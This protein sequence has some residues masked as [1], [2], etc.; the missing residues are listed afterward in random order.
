MYR[1]TEQKSLPTDATCPECGS[2]TVLYKAGALTCTN[3]GHEIASTKK[4]KNKF[5][6]V[7]TVAKDGL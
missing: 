4:R 1:Q 5:N 6:A 2:K 7:R 3:C